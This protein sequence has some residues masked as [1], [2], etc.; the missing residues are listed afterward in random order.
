MH[1]LIPDPEARLCSKPGFLLGAR[2]PCGILGSDD[3]HIVIVPFALE[4]SISR[5]SLNVADKVH[6]SI[7]PYPAR[8]APTSEQRKP[9]CPCFNIPVLMPNTTS[10]RV[11]LPSPSLPVQSAQ[12]SAVKGWWGLLVYLPLVFPCHSDSLPPSSFP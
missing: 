4:G 11:N 8:K 9:I 12:E 1:A 5:N 6:H 3:K 10:F 2:L 7:S